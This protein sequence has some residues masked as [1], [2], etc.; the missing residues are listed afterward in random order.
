MSTRAGQDSDCNPSSAAGIL[1]VMF[2]YDAIPGRW[3]GGLTALADRKFSF[4]DYSFNQIVASTITRAG[5][6]IEGAG[7]TVT[8]TAISVPVQQPRPPKLEQWDMGVPDRRIAIKDPAWTWTG[9]WATPPGTMDR[10]APGAQA[11]SSAGAEATLTFTGSAVTILG[12]SSQA[13]GRADVFLDGARDGEIDAY[14]PPDTHDNALWHRYGL[15]NGPHHVRI[16]VRAE[17]G[18]ASRGTVVALNGAVT[19]RPH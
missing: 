18:E 11:A 5:K 3:K 4:T 10:D 12:V 14:I 16:V 7:G 15:P 17:K 9:E 19:Y 8:A 13:G 1:G 6:V 2:G